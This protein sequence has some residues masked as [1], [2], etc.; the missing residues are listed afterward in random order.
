MIFA[1]VGV[2]GA[3]VSCSNPNES[4]L[5]LHALGLGTPVVTGLYITGPNGPEA[6][7]VWGQPSDPPPQGPRLLFPPPPQLSYYAFSPPYPNPLDGE[8]VVKFDVKFLDHAPGLP[9]QSVVSLW[10]VRARWVQSVNP[11][12][13]SISGGMVPAPNSGAIRTLRHNEAMFPGHY[14]ANWNGRDDNGDLVPAGFYRI[15]FQANDFTSWY[16]M[17]LYRSLNDL[18]GDLREIVVNR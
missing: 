4:D 3:N 17:F 1:L 8:T 2:V 11:D 6:L 15:Y 7:A 13:V 5:P 18:P 12:V 14:S 10:I 16:D 9:T